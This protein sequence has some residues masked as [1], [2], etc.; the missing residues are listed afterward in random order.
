MR[1]LFW[2]CDFDSL[3]MDEYRDFLIHRILGNGDWSA[4]E[5]LRGSVGDAA[6][7]DWF[8]SGRGAKLDPRGL[9]FW[10]VI[11]DLPEPVVDAWVAKARLSRWNRRA[12]A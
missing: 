12:S 1:W 3:D 6:I 10:G 2:D 4:I 7:R 9:R 8:L 11:L 5:W